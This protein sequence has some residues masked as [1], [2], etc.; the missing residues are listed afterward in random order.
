MYLV[1][2][3][4]EILDLPLFLPSW[5]QKKT[6]II[7]VRKIYTDIVDPSCISSVMP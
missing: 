4:S 6:G 2:L 5:A 7:C 3:C 1:N